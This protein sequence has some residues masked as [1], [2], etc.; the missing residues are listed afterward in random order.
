MKFSCNQQTLSKALNTVSKAV[1][2]KTT[3]PILKGILLQATKEGKLILSASDLD[4]SIE[5]T[6]DGVHVEEEGSAVVLSK[7][8]TDIIRKLPNEEILIERQDENIAIKT[9]RS[10]FVVVGLPSEE[11][12]NIGDIKEFEKLSIDKEIFK[13]MIRKS[14]FCASVDESKGIIT[15]VLIEL[16]ENSI[17]VAA[18]D[19]FRM[20]VI[21]EEMKNEESKKI[22]IPAKIL[23]DIYKIIAELEE[24]ESLTFVLGDKKAV[25]MLEN[26]KIMLRLLNGEF[27]KYKDIIPKENK[28]VIKAARVELFESIERAALL[29]KEGKNNLI[30][31]STSE[32]SL[33]I[34]SRSDEGTVREETRIEREGEDIEIGFNSK[35]LLDVLK[36]LD[37]EEIVLEMNTSV[38]PCLIKPVSG[39]SFKYL[40]LPV[41]ISAGQ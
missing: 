25:I 13:S 3:I 15:G 18:L 30:K 40:V 31:L 41:R 6:I 16:E 2:S 7:L 11:F 33:T 34:T 38:K 36:V 28:C 35:Y 5:K 32:N 4:L 27:I 24:E 22:I 29:S 19:G 26:V 17:R 37:E 39:E 20:A 14:V 1:T 8:F 9:P 23:Q 12:P 10:E 21:T